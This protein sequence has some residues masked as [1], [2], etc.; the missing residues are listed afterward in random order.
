MLQTR[1]FVA[2]KALSLVSWVC[3]HTCA[4]MGVPYDCEP[5]YD[6]TVTAMCTS[7]GNY[8]VE[9]VLGF[10]IRKAQQ[11]WR[12]D[13][14]RTVAGITMKSN[15]FM[16]NA[17]G[18]LIS[19]I[20]LMKKHQVIARPHLRSRLGASEVSWQV[21]RQRSGIAI[22]AFER[23]KFSCS[24]EEFI[25][26][27]FETFE[28]RWCQSEVSLQPWGLRTLWFLLAWD[29]LDGRGWRSTGL[30]GY[31]ITSIILNHLRLEN[32]DLGGFECLWMISSSAT[33]TEGFA[34]PASEMPR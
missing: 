27:W 20:S 1:L 32:C 18:M 12:V 23:S 31:E 25:N 30:L 33:G 24:G 17:V 29:S 34:C 11:L 5:G 7:D 6:G 26:R 21:P 19:P 10:C 3:S 2:G 22:I 28:Q 4:G 13:S 15:S 14:M 8:T 9:G 16:Q